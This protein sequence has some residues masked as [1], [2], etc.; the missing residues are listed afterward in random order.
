MFTTNCS[1]S[2][3]GPTVWSPHF[4]PNFSEIKFNLSVKFSRWPVFYRFSDNNCIRIPHSSNDYCMPTGPRFKIL[5]AIDEAHEVQNLAFRLIT[6]SYIISWI[7][8]SHWG[9]E[10]CWVCKIRLCRFPWQK[11]SLKYG[12]QAFKAPTVPSVLAMLQTGRP[13]QRSSSQLHNL[14]GVSYMLVLPFPS[15]TRCQYSTR[16]NPV[17][18]GMTTCFRVTVL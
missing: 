3:S 15:L 2:Y 18:V 5:I 10:L 7:L 8:H 17:W 9:V 16:M 13:P 1:L 12:V 14:I 4:K 11:G 6:S